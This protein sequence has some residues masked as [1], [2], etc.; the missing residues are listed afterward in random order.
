LPE[1]PSVSNPIRFKHIPDV[2]QYK[3]SDY[4]NAIRVERGITVEEAKAIAA[5]DPAIDYFFIVTGGM[6]VLEFA[7]DQRHEPEK[8]PLKLVSGG[9]YRFDDDRPGKGYM[10]LFEHGD[11]VF[12]RKEGQWLG[13]APGLA[14]VYEKE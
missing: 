5:A 14:D 12:F 9:S 7:P 1:E 10:R 3:G 6:M 8:D 13:S 4:S 2:A 11:A